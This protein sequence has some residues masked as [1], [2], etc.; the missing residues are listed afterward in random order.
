MTWMANISS[1]ALSR[2]W[3]VSSEYLHCQMQHAW[4][5]IVPSLAANVGTFKMGG[6]GRL[7]VRRELEVWVCSYDDACAKSG[8]AF[9]YI[10]DEQ[11][12]LFIPWFVGAD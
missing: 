12:K 10:Y 5:V 6:L 11:K 8:D 7:M 4:K 3:F 1:S 2:Y 9:C